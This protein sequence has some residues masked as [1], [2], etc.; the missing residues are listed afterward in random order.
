MTWKLT[1]WASTRDYKK[2][3]EEFLS[4]KILGF[5]PEGSSFVLVGMGEGHFYLEG[6]RIYYN[7]SH[8]KSFMDGAIAEWE[9]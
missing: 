3:V 1:D 2:P 6:V 8:R 5:V 9:E 4:D 7:P